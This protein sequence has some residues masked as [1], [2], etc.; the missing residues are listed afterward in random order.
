[1]SMACAHI[2]MVDQTD[3]SI[4]QELVQD[5][6]ISIPKL[7]AKLGLAPSMAYS[8]VRR[9]ASRGLI[10]RYTIDVN[11]AELGYPV[12][13]LVGI[14]MDSKKRNSILEDLFRIDG[15]REIAEVTGRFDILITAY[16]KSL[17]EMHKMVSNN[18]GRIDGVLSTESFIEMKSSTK[19]LG[20]IG[21]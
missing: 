9:L 20:S 8:R 10:V 2:I 16:A 7:A 6:S 11:H 13:M 14:K 21:G 3:M 15:V 1:M 5:S 19:P 18:M 12:K 17:E 4:L